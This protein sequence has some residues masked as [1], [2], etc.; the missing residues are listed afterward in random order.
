MINRNKLAV[1]SGLCAGLLWGICSV[2]VALFPHYMLLMTT[3][4]IHVDITQ[5]GWTLT[6][7][8]FLVGLVGWMILAGVAG[9]LLAVIYN[10]MVG[11]EAN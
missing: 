10:Q 2:F 1:A 4:M 9:A 11:S 5:M 6:W 8:G 7:S 3:H